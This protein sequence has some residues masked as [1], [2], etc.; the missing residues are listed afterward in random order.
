MWTYATIRQLGLRST[1]SP[2]PFTLVKESLSYGVFFGVFEVVKQQ[3]YYA[4]LNLYYGGHGPVSSTEIVPSNE[5]KPHWSISPLFILLAG[6]SASVAYSVVSFPLQRIQ[7]AQVK[8]PTTFREFLSSP[9]SIRISRPPLLQILCRGGLYRGFL[10]HA[11]RMIPSS[12]VAL[13]L[14]ETVRRKF[15]PDGEGIWAGQ[16]VVP[17]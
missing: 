1:Y 7:S 4:F 6:S 9:S 14:F 12:S 8:L 13:I 2:L 16:V 5:R 11:V 3:G 15:A 10:S 17:V